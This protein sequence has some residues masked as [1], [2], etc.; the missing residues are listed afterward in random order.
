MYFD[1]SLHCDYNSTT[2]RERRLND[3]CSRNISCNNYNDYNDERDDR[4]RPLKSRNVD[5]RRKKKS[6]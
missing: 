2:A 6:S 5:V 1:K 4:R 3:T